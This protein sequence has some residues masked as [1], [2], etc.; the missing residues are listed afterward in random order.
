LILNTWNLKHPEDHV[1]EKRLREIEHTI[2]EKIRLKS[3]GRTEEWKTG[4]KALFYFDLEDKKQCGYP[5]FK[6]GLDKFGCNFKEHEMRA[7]F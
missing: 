4:K 2:F 1:S 3:D 6:Q 5:Q 7:L